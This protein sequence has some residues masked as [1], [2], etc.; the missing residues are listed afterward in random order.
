MLA[1]AAW[2][3]P[4]AGRRRTRLLRQQ[5]PSPRPNA[6]GHRLA[7]GLS[8]NSLTGMPPQVHHDAMARMLI[9]AAVAGGL[10]FTGLTAAN[11]EPGPALP[12]DVNVT[13]S[14]GNEVDITNQ[15]DD[16]IQAQIT[17]YPEHIGECGTVEAHS[18]RTFVGP[19]LHK[20]LW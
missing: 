5:H 20:L 18:T 12:C 16:P 8:R 6:A 10:M 7:F 4:A 19:A 1:S 15:C 9:G 17:W 11:A 3:R 13:R 2:V 14:E